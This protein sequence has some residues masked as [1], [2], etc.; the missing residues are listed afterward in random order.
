MPA[1][2]GGICAVAWLACAS[3][4]PGEDTF[5]GDALA[6]DSWAACFPLGCSGAS[7]SLD[8]SDALRG[9]SCDRPPPTNR[10]GCLPRVGLAL[11][12]LFAMRSR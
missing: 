11:A 5:I 4:A 1:D 8:P 2:D 6:A 7:E 10:P 9:S 12:L 3:A